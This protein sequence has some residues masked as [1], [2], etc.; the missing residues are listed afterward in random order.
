MAYIKKLA[1]GNFQAQ[2]RLKGLQ[3]ICKTFSSK[4]LATQFV[5][6]VKGEL[7]VHLSTLKRRIS[8]LSQ[9]T[10]AEAWM[11]NL[12]IWVNSESTEQARAR[13]EAENRPL[14]ADDRVCYI[15][16]DV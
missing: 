15:G 1:S 8:K 5:R 13:W 9:L 6:Q 12:F 2:I 4:A 16:W 3:P 7:I 14:T 10:G 11:P